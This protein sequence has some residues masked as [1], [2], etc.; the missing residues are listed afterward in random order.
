MHIGIFKLWHKIKVVIGLKIYSLTIRMGVRS[1]QKSTPFRL[2]AIKTQNQMTEI[3]FYSSFQQFIYLF[4]KIFYTY[5]VLRNLCSAVNKY[6]E[7]IFFFF[8]RAP[9]LVSRIDK[10]VCV[11]W[12]NE[13]ECWVVWENWGRAIKSKFTG[14]RKVGFR[15]EVS[16]KHRPKTTETIKG[17]VGSLEIEH[18]EG[19]KTGTGKHMEK[20]KGDKFRKQLSGKL[21]WLKCTLQEI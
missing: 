12:C 6:F 17:D 16:S 3:V 5:E 21:E 15:K 8:K 13:G 10:T 11:K 18:L 7:R 4:I 20:R 14:S 1:L 9:N 19:S 2:A